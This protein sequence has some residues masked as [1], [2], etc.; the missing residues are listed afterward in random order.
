MS[1]ITAIKKKCLECGG[2][3]KEVTICHLFECPLWKYRTGDNIKSQGYKERMQTGFE[4]F[5]KEFD[6]LEKDCNIN[7][8]SFLKGKHIN[9]REEEPEEVSPEDET[10]E[11]SN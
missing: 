10:R 1:R 5:K 8:K 7:K 4:N 3:S 2:T 9:A 6:T 11:P